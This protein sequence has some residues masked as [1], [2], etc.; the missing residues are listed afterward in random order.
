MN[1][2]LPVIFALSVDGKVNVES[3][4]AGEVLLNVDGA[5]TLIFKL[6]NIQQGCEIFTCFE[7]EAT[8]NEG[9]VQRADDTWGTDLTDAFAPSNKTVV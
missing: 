9:L 7:M 8:M 4:Y 3:K 1:S 5:K 6:Q 2:E